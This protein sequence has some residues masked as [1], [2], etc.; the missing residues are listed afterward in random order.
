M[1][2]RF[3][4]WCLLS[5]GSVA[6]L[7]VVFLAL[8]ALGIDGWLRWLVMVPAF[9]ALRVVIQRFLAKGKDRPTD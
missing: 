9:I 4:T 8:T 5:V 3:L 2:G 6:G 1:E 7:T